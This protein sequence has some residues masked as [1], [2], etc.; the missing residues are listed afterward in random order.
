MF[1]KVSCWTELLYTIAARPLGVNFQMCMAQKF[2]TFL[3]FLK[4][5]KFWTFLQFLKFRKFWTFL[6][7][8][9]FCSKRNNSKTLIFMIFF[10]QT[11]Q[12]KKPLHGQISQ[13]T[14]HVFPLH[15]PLHP[16]TPPSP[17]KQLEIQEGLR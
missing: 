1:T 12:P 9:K 2:C 17:R 5:R 7:F 15:Q 11:V 16:P 4:F 10:D 14:G 13:H 8:L 6:Q 3:Q